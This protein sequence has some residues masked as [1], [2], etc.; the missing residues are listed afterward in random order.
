ARGLMYG[1]DSG[2]QGYGDLWQLRQAQTQTPLAIVS[3]EAN[4]GENKLTITFSRGV[5]AAT[6]LDPSHYNISCQGLSL[7]VTQVQFGPDNRT[8]CVFTDR[9]YPP[10][11]S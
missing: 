1:G 7:A 4:C 2:N 8:V 9:T 3:A 10:G 6:A 11:S 5:T